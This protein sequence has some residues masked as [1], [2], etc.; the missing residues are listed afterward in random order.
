[1]RV[2]IWRAKKSKRR[3]R[4]FRT[5]WVFHNSILNFPEASDEISEASDEKGKT[6]N[7]FL[8]TENFVSEAENQKGKTG[9]LIS[10]L[11]FFVAGFRN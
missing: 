8:E 4:G 5:F 1:M 2:T 7:H 3:G 9:T 11:P 10:G 6:G